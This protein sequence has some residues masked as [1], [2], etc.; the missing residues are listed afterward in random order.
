[1]GRAVHAARLAYVRA[2]CDSE[3]WTEATVHHVESELD[4]GSVVGVRRV[5]ILP[6]DSVE[7]LQARVLT[8]EHELVIETLAKIARREANDIFREGRLI[9]D[10]NAKV[11]ET[12]KRHARWLFPRG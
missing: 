12:A 2:I 4:E 11:L 8:F 5:P 3:P 1:M 7:D 10:A 6:G 9:P